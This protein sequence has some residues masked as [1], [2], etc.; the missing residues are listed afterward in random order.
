[1]TPVRKNWPG[2]LPVPGHTGEFE[3]A[4]WY[5]LDDLPHGTNPSSGFFATANNNTLAPGERRPIGYQWSDAAR[6][7]RIREVLTSKDKFS[8]EDFQ[9]LQHDAVAWKAKQLVPLLRGV[10]SEDAELEK[11]R[12]ELA[13]WDCNLTQDSSLATVYV[14]WEQELQTVLASGRS[15]GALPAEYAGRASR[16]VVPQYTAPT[17]EWFGADARAGR[18]KALVAA[19]SAA[20][21]EVK[22][23]FGADQTRWRWGAVHTA[24]FRHILSADAATSTLLNVGPFSRGGYGGTPFAT[25][26]RGVEQNNGSSYRQIMDLGDWDRSVATTA[27]GQSGQP[28]SPHFDD[29]AKLWAGQKYFPLAFS[30]AAV[31]AAAGATL[32]LTPGGRNTS[33]PSSR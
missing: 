30:Q 10:T 16:F 29:L 24:T 8:I 18:D 4:G 17:A 12:R 7:N 13:A 19:L 32:T 33:S 25:G 22:Q 20:V 26:G 27:P 11:L 6:I 14:F 21:K 15:D 23:R 3:W 5:S 31:Q 2:L 9:A 28:G 1:L